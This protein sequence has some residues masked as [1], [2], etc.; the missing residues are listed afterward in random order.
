MI[1]TNQFTMMN[2]YNKYWY[3]DEWESWKKLPS[4]TADLNECLYNI[5]NLKNKLAEFK[6]KFSYQQLELFYKWQ[7]RHFFN[8]SIDLYYCHR[9]YG[10][11]CYNA[12]DLSIEY[13]DLPK[14]KRVI[15]RI[16]RRAKKYNKS[17]FWEQ[18]KV[19]NSFSITIYL[20]GKTTT[21]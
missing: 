2:L 20:F 8:Q 21:K 12:N 16:I 5:A 1:Q 10:V 9:T 14:D 17:I 3:C 11:G 15:G 4:D 7:T 19:L 18:K 13:W 6:T